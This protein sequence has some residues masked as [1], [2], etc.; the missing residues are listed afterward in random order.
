MR[1]IYSISFFCLLGSTMVLGQSDGDTKMPQSGSKLIPIKTEQ[2]SFNVWTKRVGSHDGIK[3][4]LLHGGPG[5]THEYWKVFENHFQDVPI[6]Y[7]Y[8]DQLG[9]FHSDKPTDPDL[10]QID[11]FVDE[12]EQVRVAL[13]LDKSNFYLMGHSWGG[14]L[15]MEYALAYPQHLKGLVISNMMASI[16]AYN[17]YAQDVLMPELDP[18]VLAELKSIEADN[19]YQN[20]RYMDLLTNHHYV[21]HVLRRPVEQ[22]PTAVNQAFSHLNFEIYLLMQ[23][24]SELGASGRLE[25]WDRSQDLKNIKV[26]TLVIGAQFDTMDPAHMKWMADEIPQA[27]Y[28]HCPEGSHMAMYDDE[29]TYFEGV[30]RFL[31]DVDENRF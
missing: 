24:P 14:L 15:A 13:Q 27:R 31:I 22:W 8:Y 17:Q 7:Y 19:D 30:T 10:W 3:V 18:D 2:G 16:P 12:V 9:S 20:P 1:L 25:N 21:N 26:K 11:R 4:L 5:S 29:K 23:G 6:E 28:L